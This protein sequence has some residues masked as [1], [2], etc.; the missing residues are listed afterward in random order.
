MKGLSN[1]IVNRLLISESNVVSLKPLLIA[2]FFST[3][4]QQNLMLPKSVKKIPL[5]FLLLLITLLLIIGSFNYVHH[6]D[7][8]EVEE[9]CN[10]K[11]NLEICSD[12]MY[13]K[14]DDTL[15]ISE[16]M[17]VIR[18]ARRIV[19]K[20]GMVMLTFM[21]RAFVPFLTNW[22]CHT[23][24]M[25]NYS[26]VL[27]LVTDNSVYSKIIAQYP[28]LSVVYLSVFHKINGKQRY[29]SAGFMRVGIYR[30]R[31]VNWILQENFPVF[32]FEL[33]ALWIRNPLPFVTSK[34]EYD[35]TIIPT[36][37]KS[38]E[39]A[40]GF[41]YMR[42]S[43]RMKTFWAELVH[44]LDELDTTFSCLDNTALVRSKDNDQIVLMDL[45]LE[46]YR[47]IVIYFLPLNRFLDGK[48]YTHPNL[49][50]LKH[51]FILNF[52]FIIG[53]DEKIARA[54]QFGQWFVAQDNVSCLSDH[55]KYLNPELSTKLV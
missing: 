9:A 24:N 41:Y 18:E 12:K 29:C 44:R 2:V 43:T 13:N 52:N 3:C 27:I 21:N 7:S 16:K 47:N 48:W 46:H 42:N 17:N 40:I 14:N 33:D 32:L 51:A 31:V 1:I 15:D 25:V 49:E 30:G 6:D 34:K 36:Y 54:K 50:Q 55:R 26:Q 39:A 53:I 20:N 23:R 45:I 35:L 8:E 19:R 4:F 37:A 10:E 11:I 28:S 22:M 5:L 38:F